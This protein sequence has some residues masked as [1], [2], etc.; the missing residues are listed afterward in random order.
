MGLARISA[1][2]RPLGIGKGQHALLAEL[3]H[4][5][6]LSQMELS[7]KLHMDKGAV[8]RALAKLEKSGYIERVRD[9]ADARVVRVYLSEKA[10]AVQE[11]LFSILGN[12]TDTLTE[13]FTIEEK[14]RALD[15]L[16][17]MVDNAMRTSVDRNKKE[18]QS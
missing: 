10:R 18:G 6:G 7:R 13:G 2:L 5:D 17:R 3:F 12:W 14:N 9:Q 16:R 4:H 8:G 1:E 15:H 11:K